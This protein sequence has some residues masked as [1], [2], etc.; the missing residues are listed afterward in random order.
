MSALF[1]V[2]FARLQRRSPMR[3]DVHPATQRRIL[4]IS[5]RNVRMGER[6]GEWALRATP[7][8][9]PPYPHD[10]VATPRPAPFAPKS[11]NITANVQTSPQTCKHHGKRANITANVQTSRQTCKHHRKSA[12]IPAKQ[13]QTRR[14]APTT[15][16]SRQIHPPAAPKSTKIPPPQKKTLTNPQKFSIFV[17]T[18]NK[19]T[20]KRTAK[21]PAPQARLKN[22]PGQAGN[23]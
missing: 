21:Q 13:G 9:P 23:V 16:K 7:L 6:H 3:N 8:R 10:G 4:C 1:A 14:S 11:A 17:T 12:K 22:P 2:I 15:R 20:E 18:M 19:R 5:W